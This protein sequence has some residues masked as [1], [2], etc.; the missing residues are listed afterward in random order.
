[1]QKTVWKL[2]KG[3]WVKIERFWVRVKK[4]ALFQIWKIFK[5]IFVLEPVFLEREKIKMSDEKHRL[6]IE[7]R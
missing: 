5:K 4:M 1:M 7:W 3:K 2:V 6:K